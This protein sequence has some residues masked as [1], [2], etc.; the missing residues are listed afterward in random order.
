M[1]KDVLLP[2][3]KN[4]VNSVL[5]VGIK[6]ISDF[7]FAEFQILNL[8]PVLFT[9]KESIV[10][11]WRAFLDFPTVDFVRI[12]KFTGIDIIINVIN[13]TVIGS[14]RVN[15]N[16]KVFPFALIMIAPVFSV[17]LFFEVPS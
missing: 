8:I 14:L 4:G 13:R 10:Y 2:K 17:S 6:K 12:L 3:L 5:K 7:F 16:Q 9:K 15:F 11:R 1:F